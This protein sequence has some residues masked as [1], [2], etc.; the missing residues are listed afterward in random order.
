MITK[1]KKYALRSG[2]DVVILEVIKGYVFGRHKSGNN[3]DS[4]RWDD[5]GAFHSNKEESC[6]DLIEVS[7]YADWKIDD[8]ILVWE[9][10]FADDKAKRYFAGLNKDGSPLVYNN[11]T[12]SWSNI[13]GTSTWDNCELYRED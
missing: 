12:T 6:L 8:K 7:P 10:T 11:G 2:A 3:W 1:D 5:N 4:I 13:E 9:D